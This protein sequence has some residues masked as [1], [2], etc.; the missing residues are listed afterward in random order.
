M[1]PLIERNRS[2]L[3][4]RL[5]L[6]LCGLLPQV[7]QADEVQSVRY[8]VRDGVAQVQ[9]TGAGTTVDTP[10]TLASVGKAMTSV[11][12][13]R[14]V[15]QGLIDIDDPVSDYVS[16]T[17]NDGFGGLNDVSLRHL[18]TMTSGLPDYYDAIYQ[19][20]ALR[21]PDEVQKAAVALSYVFDADRL[22]APGE[23][24][25]YTNTNYVLLGLVL[26]K[27]TG[28][29]YAEVLK[30]LIFDPLEMNDSFVFGSQ[31]LPE[32]YPTGHQG[33]DHV[34]SYYEA[35]G[36]GDGGVISTA[37]DLARFYMAVFM[38]GSVLSDSM[39]DVFLTDP[40]GVGYGMGIGVEGAIVGHSGG[41][42]GF[43]S[44][45]TL[46]RETGTIAI[47]LS[48]DADADTSWAID[49]VLGEN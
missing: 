40:T 2:K 12:G 23:V 41:D 27:V 32:T 34:R 26:E 38:E 8:V 1:R 7:A 17:I 49:Q 28:Q 13:L 5:G 10:F 39:M 25:D 3:V 42:L 21:R 43:A 35:D 22:S 37:P 44:D 20:D 18:L 29:S 46:D 30:A 9:M 16:D 24:F 33:Q 4:R 45:V 19:R 36:F 15:E 31:A 6:L 48:A 11:A 47:I 14:L